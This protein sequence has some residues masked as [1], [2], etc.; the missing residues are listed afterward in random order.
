V[1]A[2]A[3]WLEIVAP[4]GFSFAGLAEVDPRSALRGVLLQHRV[5]C[6]E[7]PPLPVRE[8]LLFDGLR[9]GAMEGQ[10]VRLGAP[11]VLFQSDAAIDDN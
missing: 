7:A 9:I 1:R 4:P 3:N 10:D 8:H 5:G 11:H 6:A 2:R